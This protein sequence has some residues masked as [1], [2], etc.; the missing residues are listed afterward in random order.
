VGLSIFCLFSSCSY[1]LRGGGEYDDI[2]F[3]LNE[4]KIK[5]KKRIGDRDGVFFLLLV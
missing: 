1:V 4:E 3:G 2:T 5:G